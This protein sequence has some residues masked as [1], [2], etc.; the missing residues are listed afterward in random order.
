MKFHHPFR[1]SA[2]LCVPM[3]EGRVSAN[4]T[5]TQNALCYGASEEPVMEMKECRRI[6][7][8][9]VRL[10]PIQLAPIC[11]GRSCDSNIRSS[12]GLEV[13]LEW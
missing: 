3:D 5:V 6:R 11:K 12:R 8:C 10:S 2:Q 9:S 4:S 7:K 1:E 13:S